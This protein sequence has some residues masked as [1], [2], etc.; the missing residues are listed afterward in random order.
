[1]AIKTMVSVAD[2]EVQVR[3]L[4]ASEIRDLLK[5]AEVDA[6]KRSV[7][8]DVGNVLFSD[9]SFDDIIAMTDLKRSDLNTFAPS[10][11]RE[12][13]DKCKEVNSHFFEM[14]QR[15]TI[16]LNEQIAKIPPTTPEPVAE[17]S[18]GLSPH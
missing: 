12:I 16:A 2:K 11:I 8:F 7:T 15:L 18:K 10:E 4:I 14:V 3:E 9:V 13:A 17:Q 5:K 6:D 1:M